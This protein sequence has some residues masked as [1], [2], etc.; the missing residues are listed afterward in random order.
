MYIHTVWDYIRYGITYGMGF[1]TF[2]TSHDPYH[3]T[4]TD[5]HSLNPFCVISSLAFPLTCL[6]K[7]RKAIPREQVTSGTKKNGFLAEESGWKNQNVVKVTNPI[8]VEVSTYMYSFT[9][10]MPS[11]LILNTV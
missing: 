8:Y 1:I 6:R 4:V 11:N 5:C 3:V 2:T 9:V 10:T 7:A